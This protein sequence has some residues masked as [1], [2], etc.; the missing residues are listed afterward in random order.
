MG[1]HAV[2]G[3]RPGRTGNGDTLTRAD[4]IWGG[5]WGGR[6]TE[7]AGGLYNRA[8][9]LKTITTPTY[10]L[11]K[12][13]PPSPDEIPGLKGLIL[14]MKALSELADGEI[15]NALRPLVEAFRFANRAMWL[16]R[17]YTLYTESVRRE[18]GKSLEEV[19][20]Q[21]TGPDIPSNWP[22][23]RSTCQG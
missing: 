3:Q 21:G 10:E 16:Q 7:L 23:F 6:A 1:D 22:S 20:T 2:P 11:P 8:V 12:V 15:A 13:I 4:G 17:I 9:S 14:D 5:A 19:D 18:E